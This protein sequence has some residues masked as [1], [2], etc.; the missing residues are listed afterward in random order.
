MCIMWT[1]L[2]INKHFIEINQGCTLFLLYTIKTKQNGKLKPFK[3]PKL[4]TR[5]P[6][7][8]ICLPIMYMTNWTPPFKKIFFLINMHFLVIFIFISKSKTYNFNKFL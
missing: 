4:E 8:A 5:Q 3:L 6:A 1:G 7:L 2:E